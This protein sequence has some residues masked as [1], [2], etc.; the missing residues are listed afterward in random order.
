[1]DPS[2]VSVIA[3]VVS[4]IAAAASTFLTW[5]TSRYARSAA[6]QNSTFQLRLLKE[7]L[8]VAKHILE[9][10]PGVGFDYASKPDFNIDQLTKAL[11]TKDVLDPEAMNAVRLAR[12]ALLE[13]NSII[14]ETE[15]DLPP[16]TVKFRKRFPQIKDRALSAID[17]SLKV[18]PDNS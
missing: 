16:Q 7:T 12:G 13:V 4:A 8:R 15:A 18:L 9:N 6:Q 5:R 2:Q 1:M 11:S 14:G 10:T 3:A 17:E